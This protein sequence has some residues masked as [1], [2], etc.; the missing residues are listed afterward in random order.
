MTIPDK[1]IRKAYFSLFS[2]L[3]IGSV[4]VPVY[5]KRVPMS[6]D[7]VPPYR[8]IIN[9]QTKEQANTSKAGHDWRATIELDIITEFS[10]GNADSAVINDIE[11]QINDLIDIQGDINCPPFTIWNTQV[12]SPVDIVMDT[13]TKSIIRKV[14]RYTHILG[15]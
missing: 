9:S 2:G 5:D 13:K 8:V 10:L 1:H 6:V 11:Q 4:P 12:S 14:L 15:E 7:P 3:T